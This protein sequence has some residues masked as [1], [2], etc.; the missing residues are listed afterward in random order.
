M[1]IS[2]SEGKVTPRY[3]LKFA[4]APEA[5]VNMHARVLKLG[6]RALRILVSE[7]CN[8]MSSAAPLNR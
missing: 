2:E 7:A 8:D 3:K 6:E 5:R 1:V 4:L